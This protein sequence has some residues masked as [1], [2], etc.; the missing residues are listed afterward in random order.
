MARCSDGLERLKSCSK[1]VLWA[2]DAA[3]HIGCIWI[4]F[5][6]NDPFRAD[7]LSL[8]KATFGGNLFYLYHLCCRL[9]RGLCLCQSKTAHV[10][11]V[12]HRAPVLFLA[13]SDH[14]RGP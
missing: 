7:L 4:L 11:G 3:R 12:E 14:L 10:L 9:D 8:F 13:C 5:L 2:I 1:R 6:H